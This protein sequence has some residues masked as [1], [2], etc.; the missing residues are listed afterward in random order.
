MLTITIVQTS[1]N[2]K[3]NTRGYDYNVK[4]NERL[5]AA[6]NVKGHN[7]LDGWESLVNQI[8][9]ERAKTRIARRI[10]KAIRGLDKK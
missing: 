9:R 5:I 8:M 7:R 2:E 4:V 10:E 1:R 6:G 3:D